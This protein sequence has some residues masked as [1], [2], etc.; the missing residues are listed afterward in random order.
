MAVAGGDVFVAV[1]NPQLC[2]DH[3]D[4]Y[5]FLDLSF[6]FMTYA[7]SWQSFSAFPA[8]TDMPVLT[9]SQRKS[10]GYFQGHAMVDG[11]SEAASSLWLGTFHA[12]IV[13]LSLQKMLPQTYQLKKK[14]T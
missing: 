7:S 11:G 4:M 9:S 1:G 12:I 2:F 3:A 6:I 10:S 5:P 14:R 8:L 13:N